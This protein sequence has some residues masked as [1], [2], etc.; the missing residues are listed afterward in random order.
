MATLKRGSA[1]LNLSYKSQLKSV[2]LSLVF[3]TLRTIPDQV[4]SLPFSSKQRQ[5]PVTDN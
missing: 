5:F 2:H 3:G 1:K 4:A